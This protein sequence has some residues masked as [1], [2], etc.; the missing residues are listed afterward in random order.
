MAYTAL[1]RKFRPSNF[2]EVVGQEAITR[3]L[4]NQ[5]KTGRISHAYL[6]C[7]TRGTGKTSIA[8]IMARALN[9]ENPTDAGPCNECPTCKSILSEASINVVEIDAASNNG[10]DNIRDIK[11]QVQYP[12]TFGKYKV[13]IIDEVHML[14]TGAFN[15]LLKTLEE[16]PQYVI[17]ILATTEVHKL[18]VT[19]LSRCQRYDFKR[20]GI[21]TISERLKSLCKSEGVD[22]EDRALEYIAKSADGA[23]RD[24]LS[25]LDECISF[26]QNEK[27]SYEAVLDILGASDISVFNELLDGVLEGNTIEVL[28]LLNNSIIDGKEIGQFVTDFLWYLRN[29]L[30][31]K[32]TQNDSSLVDM[33]EQ[34]LQN[35]KEKAN[36]VS[37]ET[38][39]RYIRNL[40][41][42]SNK[43]K[44][45]TQKRVVAELEFI[46]LMAPEMEDNLDSVLDR[47]SRLES[48]VRPVNSV[49][50]NPE[51]KADIPI[52]DE[53]IELPKATYDDF[54][55]IKKEWNSIVEHLG[56]KAGSVYKEAEIEPVK[57]GGIDVI[58]FN[59][60]FYDMGN[61]ETTILD[62]RTFLSEKYG[63]DIAIR[64][65]LRENKVVRNTRYVSIDEIKSVINTDIIIEQ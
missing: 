28:N 14:S 19:V 42:L 31:L 16:P 62:L 43:L 5:L 25:L 51:E 7:G 38:L 58:F 36:I 63:K 40:S 21:D 50:R 32:S 47:L 29:I 45:A 59:K 9:C 34:N 27:I 3:T 41:E 6:F 61:K 37:K 48:G 2:D 23:M 26:L 12:P 64:I 15:A 52:E 54:M 49:Q 46:R 55:A 18:P 53:V 44:T 60:M 35:L 39:M 24:A 33:S 30:I 4:K 1:Y 11:E 22:I 10:V 13:F 17:F 57:E 56:G 8:K 65:S 20:I